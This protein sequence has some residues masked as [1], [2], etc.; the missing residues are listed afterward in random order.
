MTKEQFFK[1]IDG[2]DDKLLKEALDLK[3]EYNYAQQATVYRTEHCR[4]PLWR[5][6]TAAAA[7]L[8]VVF[9]LGFFINSVSEKQENKPPVYPGA[10]S[11]NSEN[12]TQNSEDNSSDHNTSS[13]PRG[14]P[15][16]FICPDGTPVYTSEISEIYTGSE[17]NGNLEPLT[18][19]QAERRAEECEGEFNVKCEGFAYG[20]I[21]ERAL[22][23]V[24]DPEMFKDPGDGEIIGFLG[25]EDKISTDYMRIKVGDK[26]GTL[27]VKSAYTIFSD[28]P[29]LKEFSETPGAYISEGKIEFEGEVELTG[30]IDVWGDNP[31]YPD[32]TGI[33]VFYPDGDSSVKIPIISYAYYLEDGGR[34][35][36]RHGYASG[37]FG[38]LVFDL[39]NMYEVD[40]DTSGLHPGD[41]FVKVKITADNVTAYNA[42]LGLGSMRLEL[43]SLEVL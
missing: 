39:G 15:T 25:D 11:G 40:C 19:E 12:S 10:G 23:R 26:F 28:N 20:F 9:A 41:N 37:Y 32:S 16:L 27:T 14:E 21:P 42:K 43:K 1:A 30:Y 7:G 24:D 2:V 5:I 18:L 36:N 31:N 3:S 29:W 35:H 17:S 6:L 33:M 34:G 13:I 38:D 8:A 22:N 4:R